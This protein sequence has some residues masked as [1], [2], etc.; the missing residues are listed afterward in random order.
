MTGN[1]VVEVEEQLNAVT[2]NMSK[3]EREVFNAYLLFTNGDGLKVF[4]DLM[5]TFYY[6]QSEGT[7]EELMEIPDPYREYVKKGCRMVMDNIRLIT[8]TTEELK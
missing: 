7:N 4:N 5:E 2:S 6:F 3:E 8:K 1:E